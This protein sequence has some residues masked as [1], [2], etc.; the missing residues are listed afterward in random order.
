VPDGKVVIIVFRRDLANNAPQKVQVRVVARVVRAV[1]LTVGK[2]V[3]TDL[4]SSWR[5]RGN[6]YDF[7]VSPLAEDHEMIAIKPEQDDLVLPAGRYAVVLGGLAYDFTV[8][9]PVTA[10]AQ[11]L[12]S[13]EALNGPVFSECRSK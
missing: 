5:I 10:G 1:T 3:S 11:C 13:F 9:G 7:K 8:D 12:E 6:A 2:A 4:P